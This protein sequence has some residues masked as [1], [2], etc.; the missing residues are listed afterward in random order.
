MAGD[1]PI[2]YIIMRISRS[3]DLKRISLFIKKAKN[4][5]FRLLLCEHSSLILLYQ[6]VT[7]DF[8]TLQVL[9]ALAIVQLAVADCFST[10][11]FPEKMPECVFNQSGYLPVLGP[12]N[13]EAL[14]KLELK[15]NQLVTQLRSGSLL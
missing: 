9:C 6:C 12:F 14:H 3:L 2:F 11:K 7:E 1:L 13:L 8:L 5:V 4:H 10:F 15:L